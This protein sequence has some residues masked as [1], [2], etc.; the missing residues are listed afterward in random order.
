MEREDQT[1]IIFDGVELENNMVKKVFL[2]YLENSGL[3]PKE[4]QTVKDDFRNRIVNTVR[5]RKQNGYPIDKNFMRGLMTWALTEAKNQTNQ[6]LISREKGE[7]RLCPELAGKTKMELDFN[8]YFE[9]LKNSKGKG[10]KGKIKLMVLIIFDLDDFKYINDKFGHQTGDELIKSTGK[11][12]HETLRS[13]DVGAHFS[14]DEFGALLNIELPDHTPQEEIENLVKKIVAGIIDRVQKK[15][16]KLDNQEQQISAGYTIVYHNSPGAYS[17]FLEKADSAMRGGAKLLKAF[18]GPQGE[19]LSGPERVVNF[20]EIP[21][22]KGRFSKLEQAKMDT[23]N[24]V[25]R[26]LNE[27]QASGFVADGIDVKEEF[28]KWLESILRN[29]QT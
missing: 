8:H 29:P 9:E 17:D 26:A 20:T 2:E 14:G 6:I 4:I 23:M 10:E 18:S 28:R 19:K 11:A 15:I 3:T 13:S 22:I 12:L 7:T 21:E 24:G 1:P 5:R 27:L 25:S 16:I